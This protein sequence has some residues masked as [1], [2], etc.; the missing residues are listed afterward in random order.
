M[1]SADS[2]GVCLIEILVHLPNL[3]LVKLYQTLQ[4]N[5]SQSC[6]FPH[7]VGGSSPSFFFYPREGA[8]TDRCAW[9]WPKGVL[10]AEMAGAVEAEMADGA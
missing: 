10:G 4:Q 6:F 9:R 7:S 3:F 8:T 2:L 1:T 5:S